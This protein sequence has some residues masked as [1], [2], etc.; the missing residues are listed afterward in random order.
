ME[1]SDSRGPS[2]S[3]T[4]SRRIPARPDRRAQLRRWF[5][6]PLLRYQVPAAV[7]VV[8]LPT[9]W[10]G[11]A[12]D[13]LGQRLAVERRQIGWASA[14]DL[15]NLVSSRPEVRARMTELGAYFW[16]M[17]PETKIDYW[18]P[19]AAL[20]HFVDYSLGPRWAWLMHLENLAWYAGLVA[21]CGA[22]YR[23]FLRVAWVAGLATFLY[24]FDQSHAGPVAWIAN[25][26]ALMSMLFGVLYL[27]AHDGW[28]RGRRRA[29]GFAGPALLALA[30]F[31]AES[32]VAIAGYAAAY[33]GFIDRGTRRARVLSVVPSAFVIVAWRV[34]YAGLG[35]GIASSGVI[36][37]PFVDP[38]LF[39]ARAATSLPVQVMSAV[40]AFPGDLATRD[41]WAL[42]AVALV[43]VALLVILGRA[44]WVLFRRDR[45]TRFFAAGTVLSALPLG[46]ALPTDRYLFWVGLGAIGLVANLARVF[47]NPARKMSLHRVSRWVCG[48]S[49]I[50]HG[51]ISP[52]VFP[53]RAAGPYLIQ[54]NVERVAATLPSGPDTTNQ[55]VVVLNSPLDMMA[56]MLPVIRAAKHDVVPAHLYFLYSGTHPLTVTRADGNTLDV[57]SERGWLY[58]TGDRAFR[59]T[60]FR[61]GEVVELAR[62]R[63]EVRGLTPDGRAGDVRFSFPANLEDPSLI[64]MVWGRHGLERVS[65]PSVGEATTVAA[66]NL[67]L[68]SLPRLPRRAIESD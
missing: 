15:F 48:A 41:P 54:A 12:L 3:V 56:S 39:V 25:R 37:D 59:A 43:S 2:A 33:A 30:L 55:T 13:D 63:V 64:F 68:R 47:A 6:G 57:R 51:I 36:V 8:L 67:F 66:A 40:F 4:G 32:G 28:R 24:A 18:R 65:P 46:V 52:W 58:D 49:L 16:W 10:I 1:T 22:L 11:L 31:S 61:V 7:V 53:Y 27:L 21:A 23:R 14:L 38:G 29:L 50:G 19:I 20:T 44:S 62:M 26:N 42:V 45:T 17:G 5:G 35:H 60:P 34:V 9:L